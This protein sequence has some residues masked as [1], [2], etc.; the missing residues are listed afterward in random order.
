ML[1]LLGRMG[2]CKI[3]AARRRSKMIWPVIVLAAGLLLTLAGVIIAFVSKPPVLDVVDAETLWK[4]FNDRPQTPEAIMAAG[5]KAARSEKL[6][7]RFS[8]IGIWLLV[9]GTTL[10][11]VGTVWQMLRLACKG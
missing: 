4:W 1:P 7:F 3:G 5:K 6:K 10:Q 2:R 8:I 9:A 11:L